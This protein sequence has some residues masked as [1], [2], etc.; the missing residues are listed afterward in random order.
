MGGVDE[1]SQAS[2]PAPPTSSRCRQD[3]VDYINVFFDG[4]N[5]VDNITTKHKLTSPKK[6]RATDTIEITL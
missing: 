6:E 4:L 2:Q 1:C 5:L 3:A